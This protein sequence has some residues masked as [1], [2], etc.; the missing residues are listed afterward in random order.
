[1]NEM[2]ATPPRRPQQIAAVPSPRTKQIALFL[3]S[4]KLQQLLPNGSPL[5][6]TPPQSVLNW[7]E[8]TTPYIDRATLELKSQPVLQWLTKALAVA[9]KNSV[10]QEYVQTLLGLNEFTLTMS[11]MKIFQPLQNFCNNEMLRIGQRLKELYEEDQY[12]ETLGVLIPPMHR[13]IL[14][15]GGGDDALRQDHPAVGLALETL[16]YTTFSEESVYIHFMRI[17][18]SC[19]N[20]SFQHRLAAVAE[21]CGGGAEHRR[22][23]VKSYEAMR[24]KSLDKHH[25][26][27]L[28]KPR[29][30]HTLDVLR[31]TLVFPTVDGMIQGVKMVVSS[32]SEVE[33]GGGSPSGGSLDRMPGGVGRVDNG[34]LV[35]QVEAAKTS[36][37]RSYVLN[38]IVDFGWSY[39]DMVQRL[40]SAYSCDFG[41]FLFFT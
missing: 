25:Y 12:M 21:K 8:Q 29:P 10:V 39:G 37:L 4:P 20:Q 11:F 40:V 19:C 13:E 38:V 1:M 15:I 3:H 41:R 14:K 17:V 28:V 24:S 30:A 18:G 35:S 5:K 9:S 6:S 22:A 31:S 33:M 7:I 23:D 16:K 27:Y 36:H 34:F 2:K 26:R 32:F